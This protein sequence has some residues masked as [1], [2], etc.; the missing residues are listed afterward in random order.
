MTWIAEER[1]IWVLPSGEKREGR[2]A[3]AAPEPAPGVEGDTTW[4]CEAALDGLWHR[5]LVVFG[6]ESLQPL[7]LVLRL[8]GTEL[9]AFLSRGGGRLLMP[10]HE[11]E[12][13]HPVLMSFREL[14]RSPGDPLPEDPVLAELDT[15][16]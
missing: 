1:V 10:D 4:K 9:H 7:L 5:P 3:V 11:G 13:L 6:E 15:R 8:L 12:G 14:L 2:I 16:R